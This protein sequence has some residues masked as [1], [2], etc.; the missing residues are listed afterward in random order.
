MNDSRDTDEDF[1][2]AMKQ[3]E[4]LDKHFKIKKTNIDVW[5]EK[6]GIDPFL[7]KEKKQFTEDG[8]EIINGLAYPQ[9]KTLRDPIQ[10]QSWGNQLYKETLELMAKEPDIPS[11]Q[12]R[13]ILSAREQHFDILKYYPYI[14][15]CITENPLTP[16]YYMKLFNR[17][18]IAR[19][20]IRDGHDVDYVEA[21]LQA[22]YMK[23]LETK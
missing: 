12:I 14:F 21:E 8:S 15:K 16:S 3:A 22:Y 7:T 1:I 18:C 10:I 17:M 4:E 6:Y 11:D 23:F 5:I 13:S 20:K 19:A 9:E 2:I